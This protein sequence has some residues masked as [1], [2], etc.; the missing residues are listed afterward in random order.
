MCEILSF[1]QCNFKTGSFI[2]FNLKF[3]FLYFV[4]TRLII[5]TKLSIVRVCSDGL[6][7]THARH[8]AVKANSRIPLL[9]GHVVHA[10]H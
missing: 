5:L 3:S 9:V 4:G 8:H 7:H 2:F 1:W 10:T 6:L